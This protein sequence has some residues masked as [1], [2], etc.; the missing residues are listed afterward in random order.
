MPIMG[1]WL[2]SGNI[3]DTEDEKQNNEHHKNDDSFEN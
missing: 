3:W 2:K 1:Y